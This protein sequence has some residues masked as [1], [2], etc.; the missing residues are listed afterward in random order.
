MKKIEDLIRESMETHDPP[1]GHMERFIRRLD[2]VDQ[3]QKNLRQ[4]RPLL[5]TAAAVAVLALCWWFL[6]LTGYSPFNDRNKLATYPA[7]FAETDAYYT[8]IL[9]NRI[10][11]LRALPISDHQIR[12]SLNTELNEM[13]QSDEAMR[14]DLLEDPGNELIVQAL[15]EHYQNRLDILNKL[16]LQLSPIGKQI[17]SK[18]YENPG[19]IL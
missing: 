10:E 9:K 13:E 4:I 18:A 1:D 3:R 6:Q 5:A 12:K 2:I 19:S 14:Q 15:I 17:N 8:N 11:Q 16:I 7:D